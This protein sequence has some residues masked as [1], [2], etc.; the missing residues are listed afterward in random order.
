MI[1][2]PIRLTKILVVIFA[3]L[4]TIHIILK[5]TET[6]FARLDSDTFIVNAN[7]MQYRSCL[8]SVYFENKLKIIESTNI[9]Y[10][11]GLP[12]YSLLFVYVGYFIVFT[13]FVFSISTKNPEG[14]ERK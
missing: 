5:S 10:I 12:R 1:Y 14:Y 6:Y 4:V 11:F 7:E 2:I 3:A 13:I 8:N 9:F